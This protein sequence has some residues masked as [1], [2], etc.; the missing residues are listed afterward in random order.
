MP[1]I[2]Q[3]P[4][5]FTDSNVTVFAGSDFIAEGRAAEAEGLIVASRD[6]RFDLESGAPGSPRTF[7]VGTVGAG[8]QIAPGWH[9]PM[10][11]TGRDVY[12]ADGVRVDVGHNSGGGPQ[13]GAVNAGGAVT[14]DGT[15]DLNG[16]PLTVGVGADAALDPWHDFHDIIA[17]TSD[18]LG[19]LAATGTARTSSWHSTYFTSDGT[20]RPLEVFE[21]DA[22]DL[23]RTREFRFVNLPGDVP[24]VVNVI[25]GGDVGI[26]KN[27][28]AINGERVDM[29]D[30]LGPAASRILWNVSAA[31]SFTT[32]GTSEWIGTLLVP[33]G[34]I[35]INTSTNGR[36]LAGGNVTT[37]GA[38]HEIHNFPWVGPGPFDCIDGSFTARKTVVGDAAAAVPAGTTFEVVYVH[39]ADGALTTGTLHLPVSGALVSGPRLPY[40]TTVRLTET[41]LPDLPGVTWGEPILQV[42]G[43]A[44]PNGSTFVIGA[45]TTIRV[46]VVNTAHDPG[47]L[48][49]EAL[50]PEAM[51]PDA[52]ADADDLP[53]SDDLPDVD[54]APDVD[55]LP[56]ADEPD[57]SLP[58][59]DEPEDAGD[60]QPGVDEQPETGTPDADEEPGA[61]YTPDIDDADDDAPESDETPGPGGE[62]SPPP[63]SPAPVEPAPY[64][65][66]SDDG[67]AAPEEPPADEL[68]ADEHGADTG[69]A[70]I[71]T[72]TGGHVTASSLQLVAAATVPLLLGVAAAALIHARRTA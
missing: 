46:V 32:L 69:D 13:G 41:N 8:S 29:L 45:D 38:G 31:S 12:I 53:G 62:T 59:A 11:Q 14:G 67:D 24:V 44:Q 63:S 70:G 58:D 36:L 48:L 54:D 26:E 18:A 2:S 39:D 49:P 34:D 10:L 50:P 4:P 57:T 25:G 52:D 20:D 47:T 1:S 68:P 28:V 21:I 30:R 7:N 40:G 71:T 72:M 6:A 61:E 51:P 9:Q 42:D 3:L 27:F 56:D 66:P 33:H 15:L 60:E 43:V 35:T 19:A 16:G 65:P 37:A 17:M 5:Q 64:D 55:H 23:A 22:A